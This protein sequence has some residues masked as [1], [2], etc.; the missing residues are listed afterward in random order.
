MYIHAYIYM[1][2]CAYVCARAYVYLGLP[3]PAL[4]QVDIEVPGSGSTS[5]K[6]LGSQHKTGFFTITCF[7]S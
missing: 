1:C 5:S 6:Y 4:K 3:N 7:L 2:V